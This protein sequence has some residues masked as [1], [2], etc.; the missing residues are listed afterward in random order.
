MSSRPNLK[1]DWATHEAAKYACVHWHYSKK[2]PVNKLL[3]IGVWEDG[4]F[5]GVVIFGLGTSPHLHERYKLKNTEVVELVRIALNKHHAPVSRIIRVALIFL[6]K[7][8]PLIRVV[9]SFA[10]PRQNHHG[11]IYQATNWIYTG[12]SAMVIEFFYNNDW[13]H[14]TDIFK[15]INKDKIKT[16]RQRKMNG[17]H[18]YVMPLDSEMRKQIEPLR[19]P[20]PKRDK[21]A[22]AGTTGTAEG[23][24]LPSR[25]KENRT[26]KET[27]HADK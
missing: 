11:G 4:E 8:N 7:S 19:K 14:K 12:M 2:I 26:I 10:D 3:K 20:Y 9:V 15:R 17:K 25:S 16:L 24:H 21:Q 27:D 22:M 5:V 13:R 6:K 23:Q 1:L 18:R